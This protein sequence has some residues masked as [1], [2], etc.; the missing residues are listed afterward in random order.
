[1][2]QNLIEKIA[3]KF[4][5]GLPEGSEVRSGDYISIRP[6]HVMTH[7]NT[8][9]VIPKFHSIGARRMDNPR[10]PVYALDHNV[11]DSSEANLAK[12]KRIEDFAMEMGVDFYPAGRGIGHQI[13]C[14]E[15]YAWPGTMMVASDSHS[16]MYGGLGCLGTPIVRTDA[17]AIWAT[18][19]TWWQVPP[20]AKVVLHGSLSTGT[21]GKDVILALCGLF[22]QDEVLNHAIEFAG[23]GLAMLS[24]DQRLTISNM[25]TE[26][27]ALAGLFPV[28]EVTMKW[29]RARE[30]FISTRAPEGVPS[31]ADNGSV[32]AR[33][34]V[35]R[36]DELEENPPQA[37]ADAQYALEVELDLSTIRPQV[38]G[39]H[40]VKTVTTVAAARSEKI[41]IDKAYLVSCVNSRVE[42]IAA[43]AEVMR[44]QKVA[45]G[46]E[47]YVA[48]AS[49]EVQAVCEAS[50]DWQ[51]LIDAGA[52]MLAPGCGPCIGLGTGLLGPNE[53][54]ISATNRNFKG[55]MGD[56]TALAYLASPQVVAASAL[57]GYIEYSAA[58][59]GDPSGVIHRQ[60]AATRVSVETELMPDFPA[61][62]KAELLFCHQDNLNTD[63][64]Y[65][66]KYTYQDDFTPQQQAE[67][68][69]ENYDPEFCS[70][71]ATGDVLVGG[72]NFGTGSSREQAATA[73]KHRGLRLVI[74][75]SFSETYKRNALNNGFLVIEAPQLVNDLKQQF[76]DQELTLR[77]GHTA[78]VDFKKACV[79]MSGKEYAFAPVGKAA[80]ELILL[81]G[82]ENWVKSN[83]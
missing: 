28:D 19:R 69:M 74:A 61:Q 72:F 24:I 34:N 57:A 17:A 65:P 2:S 48:A 23:D 71:A 50:G 82:L 58:E 7:D 8:G 25:T 42:D 43:A 1:M 30:A 4:S 62:I 44:G 80:Q 63:G 54:G 81:D 32:H 3:Q 77:T 12:Y 33:V 41:H 6:A 67:V 75:G 26:W 36:I 22:N 37:D 15:G 76:G 14:E 60:E 55:R 18:G 53:V 11:Q 31:D 13:M 78:V 40:N 83:L 70:K 21:G 35:E 47:F 51:V 73:L 5:V 49:S 29:L 59:A 52:I 16:N 39:P 20:V 45:D 46:V 68:V 79:T 10:Q 66:G 9:A 27:G 38:A 64:I 56:S